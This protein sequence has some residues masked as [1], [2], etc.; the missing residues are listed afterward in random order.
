MTTNLVPTT[1]SNYINAHT[2]INTNTNARNSPAGQS[3]AKKIVCVEAYWVRGT[4]V[5]LVSIF[6]R[7][8]ALVIGSGP[9]R[10]GGLACDDLITKLEGR[11]LQWSLSANCNPLAGQRAPIRR[12]LN[13]IRTSLIS[14]A[15][16]NWHDFFITRAENKAGNK[17]AAVY[18]AAWAQ[19]K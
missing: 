5:H 4:D 13:N 16:N 10:S 2:A 17:Y 8:V 14:M 18:S 12:L 6:W 11:N 19:A 1:H 3:N 9:A 7:V 15:L